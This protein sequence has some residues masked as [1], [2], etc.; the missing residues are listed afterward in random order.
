MSNGISN[1]KSK[2][3]KAVESIPPLKANKFYDCC[4]YFN[5]LSTFGGIC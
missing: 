4:K 2:Y 5:K 1:F 3:N